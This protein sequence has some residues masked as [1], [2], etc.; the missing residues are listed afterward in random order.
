MRRAESTQALISGHEVPSSRP[1][2]ALTAEVAPCRYSPTSPPEGLSSQRISESSPSRPKR[3]QPTAHHPSQSPKRVERQGLRPNQVS[4]H[5][6]CT[7]TPF[8]APPYPRH[9]HS[10]EHRKPTMLQCTRVSLELNQERSRARIEVRAACGHSN[11]VVTPSAQPQ[12]GDPA[13]T[14]FTCATSPT[15][16]TLAPP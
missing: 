7:R 14:R 15:R 3:Y 13:M 2:T 1:F 12:E 9:P 4:S 10:K 8:S 16:P 5:T 6:S 11:S